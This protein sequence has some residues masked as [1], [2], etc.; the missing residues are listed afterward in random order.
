MGTIIKLS[1][2]MKGDIGLSSGQLPIEILIVAVGH[3][4]FQWINRLIGLII[5][6]K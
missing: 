1:M 5:K 2:E 3:K 4:F 6:R